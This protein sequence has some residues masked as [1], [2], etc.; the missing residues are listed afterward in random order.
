MVKKVVRERHVGERKLISVETLVFLLW[1]T[2][3]RYTNLHTRQ[4]KLRCQKK[5]P[6][7]DSEEI[8]GL[9]SQSG[10]VSVRILR[11]ESVVFQTAKRVLSM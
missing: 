5:V 4:R 3:R 1:F 8:C 10:Q 6:P 11:L 7:L 9:M 2:V